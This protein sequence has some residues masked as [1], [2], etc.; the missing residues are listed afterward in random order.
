M[1]ICARIKLM[2]DWCVECGI[3]KIA[4][5]CG[6]DMPLNSEVCCGWTFGK[7]SPCFKKSFFHLK[8]ESLLS[9]HLSQLHFRGMNGIDII[10]LSIIFFSF[11]ITHSFL[12]RVVFQ[13]IL[14][15]HFPLLH[16]YVIYL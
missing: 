4:G 12:F 8:Y 15:F 2:Y 10:C 16:L 3:A 9:L 7:A 13:E 5:V 14:S 6:D 1:R 11:L